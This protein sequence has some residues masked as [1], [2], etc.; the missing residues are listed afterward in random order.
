MPSS[1]IAS[2]LAC[3]PI[4]TDIAA[5]AGRVL[6]AGVLLEGDGWFVDGDCGLIFTVLDNR[7]IRER[8][9]TASIDFKYMVI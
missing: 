6:A 2:S 1:F 4:D 7:H 5:Y 8:S 9:G 3:N